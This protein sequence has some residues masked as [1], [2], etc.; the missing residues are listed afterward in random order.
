MSKPEIVVVLAT[1]PDL[2]VGR[3]IARQLVERRLA[4]CVNLNPGVTSIYRWDGKIEEET[5]VQGLIKTTRVGF[6]KLK[7]AI[8][9]LHPYNTPE[10][11]LVSVD[12][13]AEG[14]L[15]WVDAEVRE[16]E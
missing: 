9:D 10:V 3:K 12:G 2:V 1:F 4:A 15:N 11:L 16:A 7:A 6:E 14:Y 5:E 8:V 13:G